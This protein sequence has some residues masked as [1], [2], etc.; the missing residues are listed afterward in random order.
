MC[1]ECEQYKAQIEEWQSVAVNWAR[2]YEDMKSDRD[3][4][5]AATEVTKQ[6]PKIKRTRRPVPGHLSIIPGGLS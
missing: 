6:G 5:K 4:I 1:K 2:L 3:R